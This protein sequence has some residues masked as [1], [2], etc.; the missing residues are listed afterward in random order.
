[1]RWW[2]VMI[3]VSVLGVATS[4]QIVGPHVT[5]DTSVDCRSVESIVADVCDDGMTTQEKAIALFD[6]SRRMMFHYPNRVDSQALHDTLHLLNTYGYSFCSQQ[7]LQLHGT[8]V[9]VGG[10]TTCFEGR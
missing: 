6:F 3:Q 2:C 4:G 8:T 5:T 7:A 10:P 9:V 1:M